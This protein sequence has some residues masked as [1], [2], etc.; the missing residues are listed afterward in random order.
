MKTLIVYL[1]KFGNTRKLAEAMAETVKP[2]GN[3][4]VVAIDQLAASD[5]DGVD[6]V[7]MGSP[8]HAFTLPEA[9]RTVL[10]SLPLA[11]LG[12]KSVAAFDTTVK[13][14]PLRCLRASPKLLNRLTYLGGKPIARPETFFVKTKNPQKSGQI[15]LLLEGELE[16]ARR[17]AGELLDRSNR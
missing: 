8:T 3:V 12:G 10:E 4:R 16:R 2:S 7:V 1:S 11:I 5:F 15:D 9:V 14:W 17:W 6:L 13:P